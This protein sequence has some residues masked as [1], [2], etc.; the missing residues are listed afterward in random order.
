[1]AYL[2]ARWHILL[3]SIQTELCSTNTARK[4]TSQSLTW[5]STTS[6]LLLYIH[7]ISIYRSARGKTLHISPQANQIAELRAN[8]HVSLLDDLMNDFKKTPWNK[9]RIEPA[10][11]NVDATTIEGC[12]SYA[13]AL[14]LPPYHIPL[15]YPHVLQYHLT[16]QSHA[17]HNL[18]TFSP[19]QVYSFSYFHITV[20][21]ISKTCDMSFSLRIHLP[22]LSL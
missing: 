6:K 12:H 3:S 19:F 13:E 9:K 22:I 5:N 4:N 21:N 14:T 2:F 17:S 7:R 16:P 8:L 18:S 10:T 11:S 20:S 1:M 15:W